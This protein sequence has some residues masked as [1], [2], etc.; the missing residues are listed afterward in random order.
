MK[1]SIIIPFKKP[2]ENIKECIKCC[3]RLNYPDFEILVLSDYRE[4]M[5][6]PKTKVIPTGPVP[7]SHK[8]DIGAE[9]AVGE[10]L[11][12]I[13]DDAYP[14]ENWLKEAVKHFKNEEVAAVGG[15]TITPKNDTLLQ[16]ASG[17][18]YSS[19][20]AS[21]PYTYR[22]IPKKQREVSE[23]PSCN[24]I[25]RKSVFQEL[26]GFRTSFWPGEDAKLCLEIT[27][28]L[29]QKIVYDPRVLVFHH[30]R[31][32]FIPHL[33]QIWGYAVYEGL[34]LKKYQTIF[35]IYTRSFHLLPTIFLLA[36]IFFPF[37]SFINTYIN[38]AFAW[39]LFAYLILTLVSSVYSSIRFNTKA[40]P[41]V[42]LGI[43]L[44]HV[45]YGV[46]FIRGLF[47]KG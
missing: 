32:L 25:I 10:F 37:L 45:A 47:L 41:F 35:D 21:G 30:R 4:E 3:L 16:K 5:S 19:F 18:V 12:F 42:F 28:K 2:S 33:K 1:V 46:G 31:K 27:S 23:L 43:V 22:Y 7:P 29:R 36:L 26:G 44:T 34:F 13:D 40:I 20:M 14:S 8:R 38:L 11:A 24:F 6:F 9:H 15:P 17:L 39:T